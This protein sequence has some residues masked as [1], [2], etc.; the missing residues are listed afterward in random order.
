MFKKVIK[1][2]DNTCYEIKQ[3][4]KLINR[5]YDYQIQ[6]YQEVQHIQKF[7]LAEWDIERKKW[8]REGIKLLYQG[9]GSYSY[10]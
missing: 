3:R 8:E 6:V 7:L 4:Q 2:Q 1:K 9:M 10:L 5:E